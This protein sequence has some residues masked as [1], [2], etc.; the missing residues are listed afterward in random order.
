VACFLSAEC[1]SSWEV[2]IVCTKLWDTDS[3][4]HFN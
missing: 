2:A 1:Q 4:R 3:G